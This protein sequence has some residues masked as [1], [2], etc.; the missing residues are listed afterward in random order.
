MSTHS[1]QFQLAS[2]KGTAKEGVKQI[3][4]EKPSRAQT[5]TPTHK[6]FQTHGFIYTGREPA[7]L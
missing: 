3:T 1:S 2:N 6:L 5:H 4:S 7:V